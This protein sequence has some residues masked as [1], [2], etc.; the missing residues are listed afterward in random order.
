[1]KIQ[2]IGTGSGK[3]SLKRYHSSLLISSNNYNL[4]VDCGDGISRALLIQKIDFE[5]I[6]SIVIS[7]LHAD[8]Y[9]GLASLITQMKLLNRK[10]DFV[11]YIHSSLKNYLEDYLL[12]SY[13]VKERLGFQL[14]IIPIETNTETTVAGLFKFD[15]KQNSHLEKYRVNDSINGLSF[16]SLSFL[17]KDN[18]E[19]VIYTGDLGSEKDLYLFNEK[20][21]WFITEIS[22]INLNELISL[23]KNKVTEKIILT[24]IDDEANSEIEKFLDSLNNELKSKFLA[25]FDGYIL[26]HNS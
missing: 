4:L 1:M 11:I 20:V 3:T 9:S 6:N 22:H 15:T 7:H 16:Q 25:A 14:S 10:N 2:F 21:N 23:L 24:H 12:H 13:I 8:H 17:F 18:Y 19:S 26:Q 5:S